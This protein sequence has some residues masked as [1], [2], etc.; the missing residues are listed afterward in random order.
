[1]FKPAG[2]LA[3]GLA[4]LAGCTTAPRQATQPPLTGEAHAPDWELFPAEKPAPTPP[5]VVTGPPPETTTA[6]APPTPPEM[7]WL[8]LNRW[9]EERR[10]GGMRRVAVAPL[11]SYALSATNGVL[12]VT[13]GSRTVYWDGLEIRLGFAPQMIDG[14]VFV[15]ALDVRKNFEPL[16]CGFDVPA[17]T[18]RVIVIDP[19]HGGSNP[20][21]RSV[22]D[23]RLEKEFTLD[24]ARR[25]AP[26]LEERGWRVF[27]TRANDAGVSLA[28][29]VAFAERQHADLF[30]SLHFNSLDGDGRELAGLETY[31]L[32]PVGMPSSLT[33]GYSD[34]AWQVFPNNVYD[35][36]NLQYAVRLHRALLA[37]NGDLDRG[38][39]RARFP[40]VLRGQRRPAVLVEGGYLS[41]PREARRIADPAYRQKLAEAVAKA[42]E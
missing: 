35:E 42:L 22:A 4:V 2:I 39:R 27:L 20:G 28:E 3:C 31:C 18:N 36:P 29:R 9:Q 1:V 24:W 21:A 14:Q 26:L 41:N 10:L 33:R 30:L 25:L 6:P 40:G 38:V 7:K 37:V 32:T 11:E 17:K 23:G 8:S 13:A 19:G 5:P 12:I 34:D 15:H 16:L